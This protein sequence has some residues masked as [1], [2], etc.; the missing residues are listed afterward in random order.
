MSLHSLALS[1]SCFAWRS[2]ERC[3]EGRG[4]AKSEAGPLTNTTLDLACWEILGQAEVQVFAC[5]A[6]SCLRG[7]FILL[8]PSYPLVPFNRSHA[9]L[10]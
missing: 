3:L 7:A 10:A 2:L 8:S 5:Q 9:D 4:S 6:R 1:S